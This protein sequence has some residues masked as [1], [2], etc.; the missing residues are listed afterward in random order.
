MSMTGHD[1]DSYWTQTETYDAL[2]VYINMNFD[3]LL[4]KSDF[5]SSPLFQFLFAVFFSS[6]FPSS[7]RNSAEPALKREL[8][9]SYPPSA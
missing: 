6:F 4:Q 7:A 9:A 2:K 1:F 5:R 8:L 3:G